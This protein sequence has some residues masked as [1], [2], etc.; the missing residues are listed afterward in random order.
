MGLYLGQRYVPDADQARALAEGDRV[1]QSSVQQVRLVSTT[2]V[3]NEECVFDLFEAES[4]TAVADAYRASDVSI[5]RITE[6]IH[7]T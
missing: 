4:V 7:V 6:A 1:R 3:P 2:S 5:E